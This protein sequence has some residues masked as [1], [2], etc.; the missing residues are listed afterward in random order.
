MR[1]HSYFWI[2]VI[3]FG[4]ADFASTYPVDVEDLEDG[5]ILLEDKRSL[6]PTDPNIDWARA[7]SL[8]FSRDNLMTIDRRSIY[9]WH[10]PGRR[11][12]YIIPYYRIGDGVNYLYDGGVRPSRVGISLS[13][14]APYRQFRP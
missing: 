8:P 2:V 6:V 9:S 14:V 7:E 10:R 11:P 3:L 12:S 1:Y 13:R 4:L 5:D